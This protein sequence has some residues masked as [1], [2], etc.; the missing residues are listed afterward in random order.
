MANPMPA[1]AP[2]T[3]PPKMPERKPDHVI[4][5]IANLPELLS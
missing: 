2:V 4:D 1:E 3:D 5:S